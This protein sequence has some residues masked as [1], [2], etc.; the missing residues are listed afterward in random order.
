M[1]SF[2]TTK[3]II[4]TLPSNTK[5]ESSGLLFFPAIDRQI[6]SK[7]WLWWDSNHG[8]YYPL[9]IPSK[10]ISSILL[11]KPVPSPLALHHP[12]SF[13]DSGSPYYLVHKRV[14]HFTRSAHLTIFS[15]NA[16]CQLW[17]WLNDESIFS[18]K[19]WK[20]RWINSALRSKHKGRPHRISQMEDNLAVRKIP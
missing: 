10:S 18:T 4:F 9:K 13:Y 11:S 6:H 3:T 2:W 7:T 20:K 19:I 12:C 5:Y 8:L 15:S 17:V 1:L 16:D 14:T